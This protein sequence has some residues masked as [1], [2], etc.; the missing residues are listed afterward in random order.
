[1]HLASSLTN[2]KS[3]LRDFWKNGL[4]ETACI[5][6]NDDPIICWNMTPPSG[7]RIFCLSRQLQVACFAGQLVPSTLNPSYE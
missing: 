2:T 6:S 4:Q 7:Y 1:V 3:G 5:V